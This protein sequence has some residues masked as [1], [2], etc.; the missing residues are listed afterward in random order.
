MKKSFTSFG[1][2]FIAL[3]T[4]MTSLTSCEDEQIA[5][6]L[7]G[8]W[9]GYMYQEYEWNGR[10]YEPDFT[11]VTFS[12]NPYQYSEGT[13]YWVDYFKNS[14]WS[15]D[16]ITCEMDWWVDNRI[17][18]IRLYDRYRTTFKICNYRLTDN[19]FSGTLYGDDGS[20]GEFHLRHTYSPHWRDYYYSRTRAASDANDSIQ[21]S[22]PVRITK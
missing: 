14:P 9:E 5:Y 11:E 4:I 12:R 8:S 22:L 19:V 18:Y 7:E 17:I 16:Y 21:Q 20:I 1:I 3:F 6:D 13:G 2:A 15:T 10:V